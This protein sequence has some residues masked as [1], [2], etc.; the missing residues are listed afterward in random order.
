MRKT[1]YR[2][3]RRPWNR[4]GP[5]TQMP[6]RAGFTLIELLVVIAIIAVLIA[7]LLPA[8]QQAREAARRTQCKNNLKQ[9]GLAMHNFHDTYLRFPPGGAQDQSPFGIAGNPGS[10]SGWGSSFLVYLTPYIDQA[11]IYNGWQFTGSS[12]AFNAVNT[13]LVSGRIFP[14][15]MCPSSALPTLCTSAS[16]ISATNYV[17]ISGAVNGLIPG[18]NETRVNTLPTAGIIGGSGVLYPNSKINLRDLTDGSTNTIAISEHGDF[19]TDTGGT[20]QDWR[21]SQ[22]WGWHIGPKC[23]SSPPTMDNNGGDNRSSNNVTIR[24]SINQTKGWT[25]NVAGTGVGSY[26]G[27]NTPINSA[28]VGGVHVLMG[29]GSVRFLS[30]SL[31]LDTLARLAIRDDGS[32]LGDF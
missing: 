23:T 16:P 7:L 30:N 19:I 18:Y 14:A 12:G 32:V 13:A 31:G 3:P 24:Y 27:S 4:S 6:W 15:F 5:L 11:G 25:D 26:V 10:G 9:L 21:A 22:P 28:H 20:K 1:P 8:V 17:G 2:E 29:D